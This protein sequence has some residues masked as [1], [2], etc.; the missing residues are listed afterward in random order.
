MIVKGIIDKIR[1]RKKTLKLIDE[2]DQ[3]AK[4]ERYKDLKWS[5]YVEERFPNNC[6]LIEMDG[7]GKPCGICWFSLEDGVCP[8]HGKVK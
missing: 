1:F 8:R 7:D 3:V 5:K 2:E 6:P 4:F